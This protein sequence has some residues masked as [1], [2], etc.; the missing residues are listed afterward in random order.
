MS[1][2]EEAIDQ[3]AAETRFSGVVRVDRAGEVELAKAYGLADRGRQIQAA[4]GGGV[5]EPAAQS[6]DLGAVAVALLL[7]RLGKPWSL[8]RHVEDRLGHD[9]R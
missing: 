7:E 8:V 6:F 3:L 4:I 5:E 9:R 2:S 1:P